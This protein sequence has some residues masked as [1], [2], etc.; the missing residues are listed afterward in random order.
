[1]S[2][3]RFYTTR[4]GRFRNARTLTTCYLFCRYFFFFFCIFTR[5]TTVGRRRSS[6]PRPLC[7][8]RVTCA[9]LP[10]ENVVRFQK[11]VTHAIR[12]ATVGGHVC[13]RVC[14][15]VRVSDRTNRFLR[16]TLF[17]FPLPSRRRTSRPF[18]FSFFSFFF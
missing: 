8:A 12:T 2:R 3:R 16:Q 18:V 5:S 10:I 6:P 17:F 13:T 11:F 7:S 14:V 15:C 4:L 1:L 9:Y